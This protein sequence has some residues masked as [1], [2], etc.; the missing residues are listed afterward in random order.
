MNP[1]HGAKGPPK[2]PGPEDIVVD[3]TDPRGY[4]YTR[5]GYHMDPIL[6]RFVPRF[7]G[8]DKSDKFTFADLPKDSFGGHGDVDPRK[9]KLEKLGDDKGLDS[10]KKALEKQRALEKMKQS[11]AKGS[12]ERE[13][14]RLWELSKQ[15]DV[16]SRTVAKGLE[17]E[18][19][20]KLGKKKDPPPIVHKKPGGDPGPGP[21]PI[22][23]V[24]PIV[25]LGK[26]PQPPPSHVITPWK[27]PV[28]DHVI[29]GP[30]P[31]SQS[32][33]SNIMMHH[34]PEPAVYEDSAPAN[35]PMGG[36]AMRNVPHV[37]KE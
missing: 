36:Q 35:I 32:S 4:Y 19:L 23:H 27:Q 31:G 24:D 9:T 18:R 13:R 6:K 33:S 34:D 25:V 17:A 16:T 5:P 1:V 7:T 21:K 2:E 14:E 12:K 8:I 22:V 29:H 28:H 15:R 3:P 30:L 37:P 26:K 11:S 10:K 20:L